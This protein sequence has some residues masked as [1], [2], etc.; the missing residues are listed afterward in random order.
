PSHPDPRRR[1]PKQRPAAHLAVQLR[2]YAAPRRRS[3]RGTPQ[4]HRQ[5]RTQ[6]VRVLMSNLDEPRAVRA[7]EEL[8]P[9]RVHQYMQSLDASIDGP[10]EIAQ[11]PGGASNLTYLLRYPKREFVLRR[12]PFGRKAK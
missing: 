3:R 12:P 4:G 7:G 9:S 8:D 2:P 10:L 1:G 6:Q 5:D 11:Y